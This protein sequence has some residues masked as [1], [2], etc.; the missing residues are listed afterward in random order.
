MRSGFQGFSPEAMAFFRGLAR[1]N[2]R[3]WFQ[4]RKP[5]FEQH[6]KQ[7]MRELVEALNGAMKSFAPEYSTDPDKAIYRIYRDTRFSKD[8]TPYKN[9]IAASFHRRGTGPHKYGGYYLHGS[10]QEV[11][12]AGGA[13][14]NPPAH[15]RTPRGIPQD[16]GC[17]AGAAT[18]GRSP[19]RPT[20]ARS[21]RLLFHRSGGRSAPLQEFHPVHGTVSGPGHNAPTVHRSAAAL[22]RH[23]AVPGFSDGAA[24][25]SARSASRRLVRP[26]RTAP[27]ARLI[28]N[29]SFAAPAE[30]PPLIMATR[31]GAVFASRSAPPRR[32]KHSDTSASCCPC[33]RGTRITEGKPDSTC[34]MSSRRNSSA[35]PSVM[36]IPSHTSAVCPHPMVQNP[37]GQR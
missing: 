20:V 27:L 21:E 7:P 8:K 16:T 13:A 30:S 1:H 33:V 12:G 31:R 18:A 6:V 36:R 11:A 28:S 22:S 17:A 14:R 37:A 2:D 4:P 19:G 10:P 9:H 26:G 23:E 15:C 34:R 32:L 5:V 29:N 3:D 25:K 24:T 35:W